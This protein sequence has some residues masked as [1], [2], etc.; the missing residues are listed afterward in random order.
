MFI[1][2]FKVPKCSKPA[3][4]NIKNRVTVTVLR[5]QLLKQ[6]GN[7]AY[8]PRKLKGD[9]CAVVVPKRLAISKL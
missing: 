7:G 1:N 8:E 5:K 3:R 2:I 9:G 4:I 6:L